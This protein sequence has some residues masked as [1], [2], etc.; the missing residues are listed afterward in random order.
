VKS[1]SC[2]TCT[3]CC[4][5]YLTAN[6]RGREIS[7]G[8][9]CVFLEIGKG[10][11][12]YDKRP[13]SPCQTYECAWLSTPE[14]PDWLKP[15]VANVIFTYRFQNGM[16]Y[17]SLQEAGKPLSVDVL[18]WAFLY[19]LNNGLN[20]EWKIGEKI[21]W[22]GVPEFLEAMGKEFGFKDWNANNTNNS[23]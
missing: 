22:I 14:F 18:T 7:P 4:E 15:N 23:I 2:G 6:I 5:G 3:K 10:C 12:E 19:A 8:K 1:R 21:W 20:F 17:L 11:T 9:P 16:K 13:V